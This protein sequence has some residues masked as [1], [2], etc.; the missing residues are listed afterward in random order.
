MK[1]N[2]EEFYKE[3]DRYKKKPGRCSCLTLSIFFLLVVVAAEICL[4]TFFRNIKFSNKTTEIGSFGGAIAQ[5]QTN[6][7]SDET[8]QVY[9]P[10]GAFCS[11]FA[12][13]KKDISTCEISEEGIEIGGKIS[14]LLPSNASIVLMPVVDNGDLKF[15]VEKVAIGKV[16]VPKSLAVGLGGYATSAVKRGLGMGAGVNFES[17]I[18]NQGLMVVTFQKVE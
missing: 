17:V 4:F 16:S 5:L 10:Q 12:Q 13:A 1:T 7:I 6:Q 8:T 3:L 9:L 14:Y 18:L 2:N 11:A 15:S